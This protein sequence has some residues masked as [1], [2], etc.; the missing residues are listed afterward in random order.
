MWTHP[1]DT[2]ALVHTDGRIWNGN[3]ATLE[4][5]HQGETVFDPHIKM[6]LAGLPNGR[7]RLSRVT[8][9]PTGV[10]P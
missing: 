10:I 4:L 5:K 2:G 9:M 3:E 6:L 7:D 1:L 8:T